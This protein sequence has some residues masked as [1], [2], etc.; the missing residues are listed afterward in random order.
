MLTKRKKRGGGGIL[1]NLI[2]SKPEVKV[3]LP[4]ERGP[5]KKKMTIAMA[6]CKGN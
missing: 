4:L 2:K 1:R 6:T 5:K 3:L